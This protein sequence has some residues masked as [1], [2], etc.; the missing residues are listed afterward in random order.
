MYL[1]TDKIHCQLIHLFQWVFQNTCAFSEDYTTLLRRL[2]DPLQL[3]AHERIIQFPYS[4][5][6][7][8]EKTEEEVARLA[9]R[10]RQQGKK[11]QEIA[12]TKRAEKVRINAF[13]FL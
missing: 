2:T 5:A 13:S 3:R 7:E 6:V 8:N 1:E 10:R 4:A 12:A 9:E 11:L